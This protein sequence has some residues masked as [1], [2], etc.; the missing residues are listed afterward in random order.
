MKTFLF[1]VVLLINSLSYAFPMKASCTSIDGKF[2]LRM[3]NKKDKKTYADLSVPYTVLYKLTYLKDD[4][5]AFRGVVDEYS[6]LEDVLDTDPPG[7]KKNIHRLSAIDFE[8]KD[9]GAF[10]PEELSL[11]IETDD[12][13]FGLGILKMNMDLDEDGLKESVTLELDCY[14]L[15]EI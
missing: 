4:N 1:C 13:K 6:F 14:L 9:A 8:L 15:N 12:L 3:V 7:V 2:N 10:T 5:Y 11:V